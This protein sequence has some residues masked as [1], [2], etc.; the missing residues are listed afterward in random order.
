M[1]HPPDIFLTLNSD[2]DSNHNSS[3]LCVCFQLVYEHKSDI[4]LL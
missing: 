1:A 2:L 4:V 3:S